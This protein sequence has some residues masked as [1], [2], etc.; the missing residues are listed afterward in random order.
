MRIL[1]TEMRRFEPPSVAIAQGSAVEWVNVSASPHTAT[2][3]PS[4][5]KDQNSVSLPAGADPWDS[6]DV[7]P[8]RSYAHV[9]DVPGFYVY[10]CTHHESEGMVGR[11]IVSPSTARS[12]GGATS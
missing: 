4:K 2:G 3:D 10:V 7:M 9:F 5:A 12:P 11:V 6:G 8:A 1:M